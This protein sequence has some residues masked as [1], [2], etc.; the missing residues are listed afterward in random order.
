MPIGYEQCEFTGLVQPCI[1]ESD[2]SC[3]DYTSDEDGRDSYDDYEDRRVDMRR[4]CEAIPG[5]RRHQPGREPD[6]CTAHEI[7]DG[8]ELHPPRRV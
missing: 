1:M 4:L 3:S 2:Y 8:N 7:Y 6:F 5:M